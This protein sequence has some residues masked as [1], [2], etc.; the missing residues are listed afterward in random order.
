MLRIGVKKKGCSG[1]S[2]TLDYTKEK[3]KFDEEVK[4]DG[5]LYCQVMMQ[6]VSLT[7]V[8]RRHRAD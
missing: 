7:R 2:Y 3:K 8:G 5:K 1:L 4:Q 6:T